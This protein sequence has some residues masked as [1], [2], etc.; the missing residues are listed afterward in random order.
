[1]FIIRGR[2]SNHRATGFHCDFPLNSICCLPVRFLR[3]KHQ[4]KLANHRHYYAPGMS[5]KNNTSPVH[6]YMKRASKVP[7]KLKQRK[8]NVFLKK[9]KSNSIPIPQNITY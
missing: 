2:G 9:I 7:S 5:V 4:E 8:L 6:K 1:M 3:S